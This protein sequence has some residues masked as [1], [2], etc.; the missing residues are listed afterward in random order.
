[1]NGSI[2][3]LMAKLSTFHRQ[4]ATKRQLQLFALN[5]RQARL[6]LIQAGYVLDITQPIGEPLDFPA[7]VV[8]GAGVSVD[9]AF[10][11]LTVVDEL[12]P[13]IQE[14]PQNFRMDS[15]RSDYGRTVQSAFV[16]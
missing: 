10:H 11:T 8:V 5:A 15:D 7:V 14:V 3:A 12:G 9:P 2:P 4:A 13:V 1:M 16:P 6:N